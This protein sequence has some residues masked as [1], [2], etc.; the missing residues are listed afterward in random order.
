MN[1]SVTSSR[2]YFRR[3]FVLYDHKTCTGIRNRTRKRIKLPGRRRLDAVDANKMSNKIRF[4]KNFARNVT[5]QVTNYLFV[6]FVII[7]WHSYK[8]I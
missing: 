5:Q 4:V 3:R 8:A 1:Q 6:D 7:K 2:V